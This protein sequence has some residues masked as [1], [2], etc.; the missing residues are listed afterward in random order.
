M[1][2]AVGER[3]NVHMKRAL[4]AMGLLGVLVGCDGAQGAFWRS[5][6]QRIEVK[7]FAFHGGSFHWSSSR[8]DLTPAQQA[9]LEAMSYAT[10]RP[11]GCMQDTREV[12]LV[13]SDAKGATRT[14]RSV[15]QGDC[16]STDALQIDFKQV[17]PLLDTL[18]CVGTRREQIPVEQAK[19]VPLDSGCSHGLMV[20]DEAEPS[21]LKV[22]ASSGGPRVIRFQECTLKETGF[23]LYDATSS[24]LLAELPAVQNTVGSKCPE[25]AFTFEEGRDYILRIFVKPAGTG[26]HALL[27]I[28][29]D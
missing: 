8:A 19:T 25:L 10:E 12:T 9:A 20:T 14:A 24:K 2:P 13:A 22:H 17:E 18:E 7:V 27:K 23:E 4:G 11:P 5:S 16:L 26:G 15:E 6:D 1:L 29:R 21:W 3:E 28:S